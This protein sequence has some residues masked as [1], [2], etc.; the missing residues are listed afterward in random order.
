MMCCLISGAV[1]FMYVKN[2]N[3]PKKDAAVNTTGSFYLCKVQYNSSP[4]IRPLSP[5]ATNLI[6]PDFK[7][8]EIIKY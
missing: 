6:R 2:E 8:T 3:A 4:L 1:R 5:K 7:W